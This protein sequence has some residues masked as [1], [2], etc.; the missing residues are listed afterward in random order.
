MVNGALQRLTDNA[1]FPVA[2]LVIREYGKLFIAKNQFKARVKTKLVIIGK[3]RVWIKASSA[4]RIFVF[5]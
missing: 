5:P 4:K 3:E 2:G 1:N